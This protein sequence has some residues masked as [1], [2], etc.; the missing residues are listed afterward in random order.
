MHPNASSS[1]ALC[2]LLAYAC[3]NSQDPSSNQGVGASGG[4]AGQAAGAAAGVG[5]AAA[6]GSASGGS[7]GTGGSAGALQ[8][9]N[10]GTGLAGGG[11][12]GAVGGS[13]GSG[14]GGVSGAG[15]GGTSGGGVGAGGAG[16]GGASGAGQGGT[17]GS[18]GAGGAG[19]GGGGT[20][21][22]S[23]TGTWN[24]MPL[25]DSI[26]GTTCYPQLLS[27]KL[28]N[29]GKT[30]FAFVGTVTNNQ[31]CTDGAITNA[32]NVKSEGHGGYLATCI[33]GDRA[34]S[35]CS[36]KGSPSELT[37]WMAASPKPDVVLMHLGTNDA[38][39]SD[40]PIATITGALTK[41]V[42]AIRGANPSAIIFAAQ[43]LPM[44]PDGC[45]GSASGCPDSRVQ[46]LNA[47]IPGWA[48]GLSTGA[49]PIYVVDIYGSIGNASAYVPSSALTGDGVHPN[50]AGSGMVADA[51]MSALA[52]K[53]IP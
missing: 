46:E 23:H 26:T 29:A 36:G 9:G 25:G 52:A 35:S 6:G 47:A 16:S 32:P 41:I 1:L 14:A 40:I 4:S 34:A 19:T 7:S 37:T 39:T 31:S 15:A 48:T 33:T 53:S 45:M 11:S 12:G 22:S 50:A 20:G 49:S 38:W 18:S 17:S 51:W 24:I 3:S 2:A 5:G 21:G 10:A 27:Q 44:H 13:A 42:T 8:G 30:T 28:K 43:I